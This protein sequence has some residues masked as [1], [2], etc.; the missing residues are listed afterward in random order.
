MRMLRVLANPYA[1]VDHEGRLCG[2]CPTH[3]IE[4]GHTPGRREFVGAALNREKTK[5]VSQGNPTSLAF[6]EQDTHWAHSPDVVEVPATPDHY[7]RQRL[8]HGDILPADKATAEYAGLKF[9]EPAVALAG[10]RKA[11][12]DRWVAMYGEK[13][14]FAAHPCPMAKHDSAPVPHEA[15][16]TPAPVPALSQAGSQ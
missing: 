8:M 9:E 11:A 14:A 1:A 7:Y 5:V 3:S 6:H 15:E 16:P 2:A 10:L 12:I 4:G 13:P